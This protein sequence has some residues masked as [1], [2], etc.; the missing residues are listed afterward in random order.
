MKRL[1]VG[2]GPLFVCLYLFQYEG[3]EGDFKN[4]EFQTC[5]SPMKLLLCYNFFES[6]GF[7]TYLIL[8][9]F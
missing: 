8:C 3:G 9:S 2:D 7:F 1:C 5:Y 6:P 4:S